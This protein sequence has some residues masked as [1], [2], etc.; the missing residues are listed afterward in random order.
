MVTWQYLSYL[1]A[2]VIFE[3]AL[4]C[5]Q[6][7][8]DSKANYSINI[9]LKIVVCRALCSHLSTVTFK[10]NKLHWNC[11]MWDF[12]VL[13]SM[14]NADSQR[15][16][17]IRLFQL[18][19]NSSRRIHCSCTSSSDSRAPR[20]ELKI[21]FQILLTYRAGCHFPERLSVK[22]RAATCVRI[23]KILFWEWRTTHRQH[24]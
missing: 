5:I 8:A 13:F 22:N 6:Y 20:W 19:T 3:Q 17:H 1:T 2:S 24:A 16:C 18:Q 11:N 14:Y 12:K 10:F 21:I 23:W 9:K 15:W 7:I 4:L